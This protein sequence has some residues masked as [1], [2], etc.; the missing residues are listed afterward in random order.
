M[1][2]IEYFTRYGLEIRQVIRYL[3]G[4]NVGSRGIAGS[5]ELWCLP[6]QHEN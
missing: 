3:V 4:V 5:R 6:W 1:L 2:A